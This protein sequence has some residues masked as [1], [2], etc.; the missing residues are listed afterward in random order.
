MGQLKLGINVFDTA[1][2]RL[3]TLYQ[4]GHRVPVGFSGGKD[5]TVCLE[6]AVLA[7]RETGRL[8]VEAF[9]VDEE[10]GI[11]GIAEFIGRTAQ[12]PDVLLRVFVRSEYWFVNA[13]SRRQPFYKAFDPAAKDRWLRQPFPNA[14]DA[15]YRD[16]SDIVDI[17]TYPWDWQRQDMVKVV[18]LRAQESPRRRLAIHSSKGHLT[19]PDPT[20]QV[21]SSRPIYDWK[22]SD[23]WLA[24][25]KFKWDYCKAYDALYKANVPRQQLRIAPPVLGP[26]SLH[27]L[28]EARKIWPAW[29]ARLCD[30]LDGVERVVTYG[31]RALIP[32]RKSGET[33][34]QCFKRVCLKAGIGWIATRARQGM[35]SALEKHR[36][37]STL[38]FPEVIPCFLCSGDKSLGSWKKLTY[39]LYGGDPVCLKTSPLGLRPVDPEEFDK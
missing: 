25:R 16:L 21:I 20:T 38:D 22:D 28:L 7:A 23:I 39:A 18:G 31:K 13:F 17:E 34:E 24:I 14:E 3:T 2:Q 37:H 6:L 30:R 35:E 36:Q 9:F 10:V 12:R 15:K 29:F 33:W 8:P 1:V 5:S 26:Q 11:P 4:A 19:K 32:E 27:V